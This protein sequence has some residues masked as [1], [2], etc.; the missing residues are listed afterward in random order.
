MFSLHST[1]LAPIQRRIRGPHQWATCTLI[2]IEDFN[3]RY[4]IWVSAR[5]DAPGRLIEKFILLSGSCFFNKK[6]PAYYNTAHNTHSAVDLEIG[7]AILLLTTEWKVINS[8]Y[9]SDHLSMKLLATSNNSQE[10]V[11]LQT[12]KQYTAVWKIFKELSSQ[13]NLSTN[14]SLKY[15]SCK[16][17]YY[18]PYCWLCSKNHS[19]DHL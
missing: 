4:P 13:S 5:A 14:R 12:F 8:H 3:D 16:F 6:H 18:G 19:R 10:N 7:S 17:N 9:G 15:W 2:I 1:G 11:S